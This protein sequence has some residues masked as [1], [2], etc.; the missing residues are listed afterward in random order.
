MAIIGT[1]DMNLML[2]TIV[3]H[4]IVQLGVHAV[5]V[6]LYRP[7]LNELHFF[8]GEGFRSDAFRHQPIRL[9][10][11]LLGETLVERK[12]VYVHHVTDAAQQSILRRLFPNDDFQAFYA[13]PLVAKT[14]IIGVLAAFYRH[15]NP[16]LHEE[17]S[18]R[19]WIA[20]LET[21]A[22][23]AS[24]AADNIRLFESTQRAM[25]DIVAAYDATIE[26][27]SRALDLRDRETHGHTQRVLDLTLRLAQVMGIPAKEWPHLRRGVLLHDIGKI[28]IPDRILH[29]PG[30]LTPEEWEIMRRHPE[31]AYEMLKDINYLKPALDIPYCHHEK[32]DGSGYPRGL[33]GEQIPL[34][35]R[36]FAVVDVWDALTSDRPYRKAF[37]LQ[38]ALDYIRSQSGTH[39]DPKV[40]EAF[41]KL[42]E[43]EV[44]QGRY[45]VDLE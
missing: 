3:R 1:F 23:Q 16:F 5:G 39:F 7:E 29:K 12:A 21:L 10:R 45:P 11:D 14:E 22:G 6:W 43:D 25:L 34:A 17:V 35:A 33:K 24:I 8:C 36:L 13:L 41:V 42:I 18:E 30:P 40:V 32:W 19:E 38:E 37:T 15:P 44:A 26:G 20:L 27:W 4:M 28:A 9:G 2:M 31:V